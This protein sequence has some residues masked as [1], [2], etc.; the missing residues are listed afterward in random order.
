M[1]S[2]GER[3]CKHSDGLANLLLFV[4]KIGSEESTRG[5]FESDVCHLGGRVYGSTLPPIGCAR[6]CILYDAVQHLKAAGLKH[7]LEHAPFAHPDLAVAVEDALADDAD[8]AAVGEGILAVVGR[9]LYKHALDGLGSR[10]HID[11]NVA[12]AKAEEAAIPSA[13]L[14]K[15]QERISLHGSDAA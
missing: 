15:K 11:W 2:G 14:D 8:R 4:P 3:L 7:R 5:D 10:D 1:S 13:V 12:R 6:C 9:V